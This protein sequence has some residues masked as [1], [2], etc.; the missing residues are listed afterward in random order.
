MDR[1]YSPWRYGYVTSTSQPQEECVFC[2]ASAGACDPL[3][4]A[5]GATAYVILNLYP[6]NSGHVMVVPVRHAASLAD[7]TRD[8]LAELMTLTQR[9]EIALT[10]VYRPQGINVG[11]NLGRAAGAG[12]ADHLHIHLVPR[13]TGDTNFMSVVGQT[14]V[15]PE[16]VPASADR[17]RPA[18]ERLEKG[19]GGIG[20]GT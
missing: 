1:L 14:R 6:Y 9:A 16:E 5:R 11:L 17:L 2:A 13:W 20:N 19:N 18:F 12:I 15:L 10:E 7:L 4:V 8:E 3:I